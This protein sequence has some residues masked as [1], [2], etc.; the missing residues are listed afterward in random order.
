MVTCHPPSTHAQGAYARE[1]PSHQSRPA[2]VAE[3]VAHRTHTTG[4][5]AGSLVIKGT[6]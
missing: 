2:A 6:Q 5:L 4:L 3:R 1:P